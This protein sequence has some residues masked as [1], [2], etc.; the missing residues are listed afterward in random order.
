MNI[1][2]LPTSELN[3][4]ITEAQAE[5]KKR[6]KAEKTDFLKEIKQKAKALG[7]SATSLLAELQADKKLSKTKAT[8]KKK[9]VLPK[10]M[11]KYRNPDNAKET[12]TGRGRQPKWVEA[13]VAKG[14]SLTSMLI[15]S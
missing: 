8:K 11:P 5:I 12:W 6:T 14:V 15:E 2:N 10:V 13:Q 3:R 4:L 9:R 7:V 1:K